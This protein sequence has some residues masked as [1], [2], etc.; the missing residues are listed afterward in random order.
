MNAAA[1]SSSIVQK[2]SVIDRLLPVWI[3]AA[4]GLGIG[5]GRA[6]PDLGAKL[7]T[8]KLDTVSLPIAVGLLWMMYPV[9]AKV[10]YG[11]LGRLRTRGKLFTTS[12]VLNWVV[13]P[14]LMFALA[15]LFLPDLPEYRN[16]L[17]L[18]GLARCIAMVLIWNML[19]CGSNEVAAVLVALNSVFQILFYSVLGWL[20]LTVIPGWLGAEVTAFDVSMGSIARSVLIFLGVPLVAGALTRIGLTRLKGE[21]WYEQRFLP[22]LGPTA[23][24]GLLYTIVLMFAMQ[25]EKITRLP[26]DV[27]RISLPLIVYFV[28][29][30]TSAFFLSRKL[31]F[32]YEE[33]ASLSFTAAGNNFELAIAV[34]VGVFG[35]SSGEALAGVVGPLIEVPALIALV[36]LS[37]WL[38]RRLFPG[39]DDAVLPRRFDGN[40]PTSGPGEARP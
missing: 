16:G 10:R 40:T 22:R 39:A 8:V 2:L 29:M 20:F 21:A 23:L 3:F 28:I 27:V 25:G 24:I 1:P 35:M 4:M 11:E 17:V 36:Y 13:G 6:F 15:W 26:L 33:T 18:I 12:L 38:K 31:G 5:L 30:F 37:L 9:L 32:S 14:V 34:A 19:A 7:D